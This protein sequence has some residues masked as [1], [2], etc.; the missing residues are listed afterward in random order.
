VVLGKSQLALERGFNTITCRPRLGRGPVTLFR[1][2]GPG[3]DK[4][5]VATGELESSEL[6]PSLM[7]NIR[8]N[9]NRWDFLDQC[10]GNHYVVVA[11]DIRGELKVLCTWLGITIFKT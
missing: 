1:F 9:G 8:L 10:F 7:V 3:C 2:Y 11:G 6:S 5:H 4:M